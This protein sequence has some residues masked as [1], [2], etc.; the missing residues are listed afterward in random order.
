MVPPTGAV[1][2]IM[3]SAGPLRYGDNV[4]LDGTGTGKG[5]AFSAMDT[6][7]RV[8]CANGDNIFVRNDVTGT[9][10]LFFFFE[11]LNP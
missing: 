7:V 6:D 2:M 1:V 5:Y 10:N 11:M 4:T 8:P 3:Q 9:N